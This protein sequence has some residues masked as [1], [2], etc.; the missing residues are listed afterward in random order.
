MSVPTRL[1]MLFLTVVLSGLLAACAG[2]LPPPGA[3]AY[4][5]VEYSLA[6][7]DKLKIT[8]FGEESLSAEYVVS[9]AGDLSFPLL[10][11]LAVE[12]KTVMQLQTEIAEQLGQGYLNDP[13]VSV[14]V[15]NYRPFYI[16]GEVERPGKYPFNDDLTVEQ[17]V[18]LAGGYSYRANTSRV[19]IRRADSDEEETYELGSS[20]RVFV[21]PGDTIRVGERYF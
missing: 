15:L 11:D 21:A 2:S 17:A 18:A 20:R 1:S 13:R 9:S 14:E 19:F 7:G 8:V 4:S 5:P 16:L 6:A 12:G 3:A 10:G